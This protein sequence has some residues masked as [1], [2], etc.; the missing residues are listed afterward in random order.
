MRVI[1]PN[2]L[3]KLDLDGQDIESA[4]NYS[5]TRME[6]FEAIEARLAIRGMYRHLADAG[7]FTECL[8]WQRWPVAQE[9]DNT[10]LERAYLKVRRTLRYLRPPEHVL[11][12]HGPQREIGFRLRAAA[13]AESRPPFEESAHSRVWRLQST[14]G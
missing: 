4:L 14:N 3:R 12:T 11:E 6:Q 1:D 2:T 7:T 5:L 13:R 10:T 9:G 8:T